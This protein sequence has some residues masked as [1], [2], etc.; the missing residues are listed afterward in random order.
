V[1]K[2]LLALSLLA[3]T[4]VYGISPCDL[5]GD[6]SVN[7]VDYQLVVNMS[8]GKI[9]CT[10]NINGNGVCN[11]ITAQ[12]I[13]NA[14]LGGSCITTESHSVTLTWVASTSNGVAGYN[15]YRS[16]TSGGPYTQIGTLIADVLYVDNAVSAG[17]TYYYVVKAVGSDGSLSA[18]SNEASGTIPFP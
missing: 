8:L 7:V 10:A 18:A 14:A 9:P 4:P 17:Q 6:G 15:M 16:L 2:T 1:I 13:I 5:N 3:V 12:R 11:V